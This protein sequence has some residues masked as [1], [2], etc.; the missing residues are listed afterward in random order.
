MNPM[1]KPDVHH[2]HNEISVENFPPP[3]LPLPPVTLSLPYFTIGIILIHLLVFLYGLSLI[4]FDHVQF[5]LTSPSLFLINN[6]S[7]FQSAL[8]QTVQI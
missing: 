6:S 5:S 1:R 4:G 2:N 3:P 7:F 8:G